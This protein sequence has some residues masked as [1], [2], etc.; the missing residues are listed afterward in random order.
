MVMVFHTCDSA[1]E[2]NEVGDNGKLCQKS[3]VYSFNNSIC[4]VS[5]L[6]CQNVY[7]QTRVTNL[8]GLSLLV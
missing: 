1:L 4:I 2:D 8:I 5:A 3:S 7:N 6:F